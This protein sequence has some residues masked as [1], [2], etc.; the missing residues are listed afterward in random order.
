MSNLFGKRLFIVL[1]AAFAGLRSVTCANAQ[2]VVD[3][4]FGAGGALA[5]V[6]GNFTIGPGL[7]VRLGSNLFDSF[8]QFNI[9]TGQ[10]ATFTGPTGIANVISRVTGPGASNID[11]TL[12]STI[13]GA[14][15]YLI[16]PN[17]VVF[18]PHAEL[19]VKGSFTATTANKLDL[20]GHGVYQA[21]RPAASKLTSAPPAAF[22]FLG[23]APA[24]IKVNGSQLAVH[25]GK[26]VSLVSGPLKVTGDA[27]VSAPAGRINAVSVAS[28]GKVSINPGQP[29]GA[30]VASKGM[31]F[32]SM[33]ISD[34]SSLDT[35]DG[36]YTVDAQG[37]GGGTIDL[38]AGELTMD[39]GFLEAL[40]QGDA[41]GRDIDVQ[42][43]GNMTM[44]HLSDIDASSSSG[45]R[46]GDVSIQAGGTLSLS[47]ESA[48]GVYATSI[49]TSAF[50]TGD[51]GELT[52]KAGNLS[53]SSRS[54]LNTGTESSG[55]GGDL[56]VDVT[57]AVQL[58]SGGTIVAEGLSGSSGA[59]GDL[60]INAGTISLVGEDPIVH[61]QSFIGA[62]SLGTG[63][64][65]ELFIDT[66]TLT[67]GDHGEIDIT[68]YSRANGGTSF[69]DA[70]NM[71]DVRYGGIVGDDSY[72]SGNGGTLSIST[73]SLF[74]NGVIQADALDTG[75]G[76]TVT[77][78]S[79]SLLLGGAGTIMTDTF[80]QA[81]GGDLHLDISG[82]AVIEGTIDADVGDYRSSTIPGV[83]ATNKKSSG[84]GGLL[85]IAAG[86]LTITGGEGAVTA[87]TYSTSG[88]GKG[89]GGDVDISVAG[90]VNVVNTGYISADSYG[91][92][93]GGSVHI[94]SGSLLVAFGTDTYESAISTDANARGNGGQ[95]VIGTNSLTVGTT[96]YIA[97]DTFSHGNGGDLSIDVSGT[98]T[99][100]GSIS[101]DVGEEGDDDDPGV[102]AL[103]LASTGNGGRL[104][105]SAGNLVLDAGTVTANT[106][107]IAGPDLGRGGDVQVRASGSIQVLDIGEISTS[108]YASGAGGNLQI[109]APRILISGSEAD[110]SDPDSPYAS[111]VSVIADGAG[112]AG[113]LTISGDNLTLSK[114]GTV[115]TSTYGTG[116]AGDIAL[117]MTG[118]LQML[119]GGS[120]DA[121]SLGGL[122]GG[123]AGKINISAA[124]VVASGVGVYE[125]ESGIKDN[126]GLSRIGNGNLSIQAGSL[127]VSNG[128]EIS[129]ST[130]GASPAG[131]IEVSVAGAL[132]ILS[133]GSIVGDT[134]G[135]GKASD[136]D[137]NAGRVLISGRQSETGGVV[138]YSQIASGS[139]GAGPGG[140]VKLTAG[141]LQITDQGSIT[142]SASEGVGGSI[143]LNA[144][145]SLDL[146]NGAAVDA[147]SDA[148]GGNVTL[149]AGGLLLAMNSNIS[150]T[151]TGETAKGGN[152][153]IGD[154][155][156]FL[157]L[158]DTPITARAQQGLGGAISNGAAFSFATA[159]RVLA[160]PPAP[161]FDADGLINP[162]DASSASGNLGTVV[163]RSPNLS[164]T[165][166]L[167]E[168]TY[169]TPDLV[170]LNQYKA[171]DQQLA[172]AKHAADSYLDAA[173]GKPV[174]KA[175]PSP[176][177]ETSRESHTAPAKPLPRTVSHR[178][179]SAQPAPAPSAPAPSMPAGVIAVQ[180]SKK[181]AGSQDTIGLILIDPVS[182]QPASPDVY[183][184]AKRRLESGDTVTIEGQSA[185]LVVR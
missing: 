180:V 124:N 16:N 137:V 115:S 77:I 10:T 127:T 145:N 48:N 112:N 159:S 122:T 185:T 11:G 176:A 136:I 126:S 116:A 71:I 152:V 113:T 30:I 163:S 93:D 57:G 178:A 108:S 147:Q 173:A 174:P 103:N 88:A 66:G 94:Q 114:L 74:V 161:A 143:T 167:G 158:D 160:V 5:P 9:G 70:S 2:I 17:G 156:P 117:S 165:S 107:S 13:P 83:A 91:T 149:T 96:G 1:L 99:I 140:D 4:S 139:F 29:A 181:T 87:D 21:T 8:Q 82:D 35:S 85:D 81:D 61:S 3:H 169:R 73:G 65:G 62:R 79:N 102:K 162:F 41:N 76:G 31:A 128:A 75:K 34:D 110:A 72:S 144:S 33:N 23:K 53:L 90:S 150:A 84:H 19:D 172:E 97:A 104:S 166:T 130:F 123:Q 18:G 105:L 129:A 148:G 44:T 155:T 78:A 184:I 36:G 63:A 45:G 177:A 12:G 125:I 95:V 86:N 32:G 58:R 22:G 138:N 151:T 39:H 80:S 182:R 7:G 133:G 170:V 121:F 6:N 54:F 142:T 59:A 37:R 47:G 179:A 135:T 14:N 43:S 67:V 119:S 49:A 141:R 134:A 52:V 69:I 109:D 28:A 98:A 164:L 27:T 50:S 25:A 60:S 38:R 157:I 153:T 146:S 51:A 175:A 171:S 42:V 111:F 168:V 92:G 118:S 24:A 26:T 20:K 154:D 15:V 64:P 183:E 46:A 132:D 56:T 101:T 89:H 68:T 106:Y 55:A 100:R 40:V 120:V 131:E